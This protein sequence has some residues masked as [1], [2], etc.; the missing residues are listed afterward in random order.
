MKKFYT[1]PDFELVQ[2]K[3]TTDVL[4]TSSEKATEEQLPSEWEDFEGDIF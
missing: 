3:L 4:Y 1:E 2:I